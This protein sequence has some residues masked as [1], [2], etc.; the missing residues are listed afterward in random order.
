MLIDGLA[1]ESERLNQINAGGG[2]SSETNRVAQQI[3]ETTVAAKALIEVMERLSSVEGRALRPDGLTHIPLTPTQQFNRLPA[4]EQSARL[5]AEEQARQ[6]ARA[7]PIGAAQRTASATASGLLDPNPD[8]REQARRAQIQETAS[9]RPKTNWY[10]EQ[11]ARA[12][13]S[14]A[15]LEQRILESKESDASKAKVLADR[16][17][18]AN[19]EEARA[20]VRAAKVASGEEKEKFSPNVAGFQARLEEQQR[21]EAELLDKL[22]ANLSVSKSQVATLE[23]P[24]A[25]KRFPTQTAADEA[26]DRARAKRESDQLALNKEL[27]RQAAVQ[28]D[29]GGLDESAATNIQRKQ[30]ALAEAQAK[31]ATLSNPDSGATDAQIADANLKLKEATQK[32]AEARDREAREAQKAR[33][34]QEAA[35]AKV[36]P[37]LSGVD[38]D[39]S[40][41][42]TNLQIEKAIADAKVKELSAAKEAGAVQVDL[43]KAKVRSR[44][45]EDDLLVAQAKELATVDNERQPK[46][47]FTGLTQ[48]YGASHGGGGGG[49]GGLGLRGRGRHGP[50]V[51]RPVPG[52][53]GWHGDHGR[54]QDRDGGVHPRGERPV[55]RVGHQLRRGVEGR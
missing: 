46:G 55:G 48:G 38:Y 47:F 14:R 54:D 20:K 3:R 49:A 16:G 27:T 31:A 30:F 25:S 11:S 41:H 33:A 18:A 26:Y 22:R 36:A 40:P 44:K 7:N 1:R 35:A 52:V 10:D 13:E 29:L 15:T 2:G 12:A 5:S 43:A 53:L 21:A 37:D 17:L 19:E 50:E 9:G 24:E 28:P 42:I 4:E 51:L 45:L 23:D 6:A 34:G 8:E 39:A 32:L